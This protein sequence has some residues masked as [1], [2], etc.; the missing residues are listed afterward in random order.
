MA[1]TAIHATELATRQ[2]NADT[3]TRSGFIAKMR[4]FLTNWRLAAERRHFDRM[5]GQRWC[6]ATERQLLD[7]FSAKTYGLEKF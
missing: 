6:D 1:T 3:A 2:N 4:A 5:A 7:S